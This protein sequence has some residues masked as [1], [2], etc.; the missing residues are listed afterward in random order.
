MTREAITA[1]ISSK[2]AENAL[3]WC[4]GRSARTARW[5]N[6]PCCPAAEESDCMRMSRFYQGTCVCPVRAPGQNENT[7]PLQ[8][9]ESFVYV[10]GT[11]VLLRRN[12][13]RSLR[14]SCR[15]HYPSRPQ[16]PSFHAIAA[17][18]LGGIQ[19]LVGGANDILGFLKSDVRLRRSNADRD[20]HLLRGLPPPLRPLLATLRPAATAAVRPAYR[21]FCLLD[22]PPQCIQVRQRFFHCLTGKD[23]CELLASAAVGPTSTSDA[24]QP[25]RHHAQHL[26]TN[27]MTIGVVE[28]L[29]VIHVHHGN[30]VRL[31][32]FA[33]RLIERPARRNPGE[34]VVI[35]QR[36]GVLDQGDCQ[37]QRR[38]RKIVGRQWRR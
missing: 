26:V 16:R 33:D 38:S 29:E 24:R 17:C 30:G 7:L 4:E 19:R 8:L 22:C 35:G 37:H 18:L 28:L 12:R 15:R 13:P 1:A 11:L 36:V 10:V 32:Q 5:I 9:R 25:A 21:K 3:C 27:V 23:N 14:C 34:F 6:V 20:R 2:V 31:R